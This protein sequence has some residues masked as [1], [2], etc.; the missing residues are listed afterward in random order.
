MGAI[1]GKKDLAYTFAK[2][3]VNTRY[4]DIPRDVVEVTKDSILDTL[5]VMLGATG[6]TPGI[7]ELVELIKEAGGR[8]E[9]T[10][11][12]FGGK[13]PAWM[14]A[15]VNGAMAHCL[16]YDDIHDEAALHASTP[17]VPSGFAI[18]ERLGKV[19]GRD[20]IAAIAIG[21]DLACRLGLAIDWKLDWHITP[22]FGT[23]SATAVSAKLLGL[24]QERIVDALGISLCQAACTMELAYSTGSYLRGM[25]PAF[26]AKAGVLSALMASR[27]ITGI[28]NTFEGRAGLFPVYF[29]G[30]YNRDILTADLG[31]R[32]EGANT[33][34]KFWPS[35]RE[36]HAFIEAT[37][38]LIS[39]HGL[40]PDDIQE[41]VTYEGSLA[42]TC[43]E[44]LEGRRKPASSLD[45][46]FS[47][48][49]SVAVAASRGAVKIKDF[50]PDGIKDRTALAMAQRVTPVLHKPF[51]EVK[52]LTPGRVEIRTK[53]GPAYS[54]TV[55]F[56]Y[57][58]PKNPVS[59][60]DLVDKFRDCAAYAVRPVPKANVDRVIELIGRLE[61]VDDV[62]QVMGLLS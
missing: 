59:K 16:D 28:K 23:F 7:K 6:V 5:G 48:P 18:A 17:T 56:A 32:F 37:L 4:Q 50:T 2:Y 26:P 13:V 15:F 49:F 58:H 1:E 53:H 9:S 3:V 21:N 51:D 14:A 42:H 38:G 35:C 44:P 12:A 29:G 39:E 10:I 40:K 60:Q 57:G 52:G 33:S 41:I 34:F 31:K 19:G 30:E 54:R 45:A 47:I 55:E 43:S 20:F 11:L 46:K 8:E 22:L 27:G 24:D 62:G 36:T 61:Q 25:Y